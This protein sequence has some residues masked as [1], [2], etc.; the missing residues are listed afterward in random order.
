MKTLESVTKF[1]KKHRALIAAGMTAT[2]FLL[3]MYRNARL[4]EEFLKDNNVWNEYQ[5]WLTE[6]L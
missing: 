2:A 3:L 4:L 6:G 5:E 1:L